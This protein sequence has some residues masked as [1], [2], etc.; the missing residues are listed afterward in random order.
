MK[1]TL[2]I[3]TSFILIC[4]LFVGCAQT[5][6]SITTSKELN[7]NL[8]ILSNTVKRLDTIDN[9]YFMDNELYSFSNIS[10]T[11]TPHKTQSIKIANSTNV[12]INDNQTIAEQTS[13]KNEL[14]TALENEIINRLYCDSEGNCKLCNEKFICDENGICTSC[15]KTIICDTE[16]NCS[17]CKTTL[18]I[19]DEKCSN[20]NTKCTSNSHQS[21]NNDLINSLKTISNK[22]KD[23][24]VEKISSQTDNSTISNVT[25]PTITNISSILSDT[26]NNL[27][28]D[29]TQHTKHIDL[30]KNSSNTSNN[31]TLNTQTIDNNLESNTN[32]KNETTN[33][34][35]YNNSSSETTDE[36]NDENF[37][38]NLE[39]D[40]ENGYIFL[41]YSEEN[42]TPDF[43]KYQ[44]RHISEINYS[45]ANN[46]IENYVNKL[47]KLY[48]MSNDVIEANNQLSF[49]KEN[50]L[51]NIIET[52]ELNKCILQGTCSPSNNQ[53]TALNNYISDMR[54]T[55]NNLR[56]CNGNLSSEINK[57]SSNNSGIVQSL[58]ITNSNYLKLLNQIDTRI[59]YHKNAIATLEQ[60]QYLLD[61]VIDNNSNSNTNI[62]PD[63]QQ[64]NINN[65][66]SNLNINEQYNT[67]NNEEKNNNLDSD[68]TE[69]FDNNS[70]DNN[71]ND[72]QNDKTTYNNNSLL[73][74]QESTNEIPTNTD[75]LN[76]EKQDN[77]INPVLE[78]NNEI[79]TTKN[80]N[81]S[82]TFSEN[83]D[84]KNIDTY[85]ENTYSNLD[86][87]EKKPSLNI[88][89]DN[90]NN[91][92]NE[93]TEN[94]IKD[95]N[96]TIYKG[97]TNNIY[98][99]SSN[100][101]TPQMVDGSINNNLANNN[102]NNSTDN[103]I[104]S[105]NNINN[106]HLGNNSYRYDNNGHLYN[107]TNGYNNNNINN[108]NK[109]SNNINT[110]KYNT[111][112][113]SIN[114]GTVNNGINNL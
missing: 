89:D 37:S 102:L 15:N 26:N 13:L 11:P 9:Q 103:T 1:K 95:D 90:N 33:N 4:I 20:C 110:Y 79:N 19:V 106:N 35:L 28:D 112:V 31:N 105:Q 48:T 43:L 34:T 98:S 12:I 41:Y 24:I 40:N 114:R 83:N 22:N 94:T 66:D 61:D 54:N 75:N 52:K 55:I 85:N 108:I 107:N 65:Q 6:A 84:L 7:K 69:N 87:S 38:I 14:K 49:H 5:D 77:I 82:T 57:I 68:T 59:S 88:Q 86:N 109:N 42:F 104:I 10:S 78:T 99:S 91:I 70:M 56:N 76:I 51:N 25:E 74:K 3:I 21:Q 92:N 100:S 62:N 93:N 97:S 32:N 101:N 72:E 44:P 80:N 53:I 46:N 67:D 45:Q 29:N 36:N 96:K 64:E 58:E 50:L 17:D 71:F 60:I 8:N 27:I 113:D 23:F 18:N 73:D 2:L 63:I 39:K 30:I 16:G 47:Q 81:T 111:L